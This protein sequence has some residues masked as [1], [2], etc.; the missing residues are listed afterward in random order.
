MLSEQPEVNNSIQ[1]LIEL[2]SYLNKSPKLFQLMQTHAKKN[3]LE[4]LHLPKAYEIRWSEFLYKLLDAFMKSWRAIYSFLKQ[5]IKFEKRDYFLK[6]V[7]DYTSMRS[8]SFMADLSMI[9]SR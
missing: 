4:L 3:H 2:S 5:N 6:F 9:F 8:I 7:T 1:T